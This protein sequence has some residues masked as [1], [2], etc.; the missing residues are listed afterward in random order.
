[1][2]HLK[3]I[4]GF[5]IEKPNV[6]RNANMRLWGLSKIVVLYPQ[7]TIKVWFP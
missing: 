7:T 5:L 4:E 1:M 3:S 6:Y 2:D